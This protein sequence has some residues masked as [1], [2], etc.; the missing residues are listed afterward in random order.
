MIRWN[1][2]DEELRL[3]KKLALKIRKNQ[4]AVGLC[5]KALWGLVN[6]KMSKRLVESTY[7][8]GYRLG[9]K[10]AKKLGIGLIESVIDELKKE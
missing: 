6:C 4:Q 9:F 1:G 8:H 10:E 7:N 2:K 3:K 5:E